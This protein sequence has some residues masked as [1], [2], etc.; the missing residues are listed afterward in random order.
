M[1]IP[2]L[3]VWLIETAPNPNWVGMRMV[4]KVSQLQFLEIKYPGFDG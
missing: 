3:G 2:V 4:L 1:Y